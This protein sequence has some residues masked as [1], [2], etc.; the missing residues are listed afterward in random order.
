MIKN[1]IV[2]VV[3]LGLLIAVLSFSISCDVIG[4]AKIY[5]EDMSVDTLSMEGKQIKGLPFAKMDI[6]LKVSAKEIKVRP[7]IDGA[8]IILNPSGAILT[9]TPDGV[10]ISGIEP[11]QMKKKFQ[12]AE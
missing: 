7:T 8:E 5:L 10:S 4:G 3:L 11:E 12:K 1:S 2:K 9:I 6:E